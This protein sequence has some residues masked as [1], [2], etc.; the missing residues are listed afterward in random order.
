MKTHNFYD[1]CFDAL[2]VKKQ[3]PLSSISTHSPKPFPPKALW[4]LFA[5]VL[6]CISQGAQPAQAQ[7]S[8]VKYS[9]VR[10]DITSQS[11]LLRLA[12]AG[13]SLDSID[14]QGSYFDAV[15]NDK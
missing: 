13:V 14:Y 12:E 4:A 5:A 7:N 3:I 10:V 11:D 2:S 15:L 6:F 8:R 9:H 1:R